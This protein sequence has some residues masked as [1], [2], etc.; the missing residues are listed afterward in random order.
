M[1][2]ARNDT[3]MYEGIPY[4]IT[5][6][7]QHYYQ[8]MSARSTTKGFK[9]RHLSQ[10]IMRADILFGAGAEVAGMTLPTDFTAVRVWDPVGDITFGHVMKRV[11][12][13]SDTKPGHR[14][15]MALLTS[16]RGV[17][18]LEIAVD[19]RHFARNFCRGFELLD[20]ATG[21]SYCANI[22]RIAVPSYVPRGPSSSRYT[23]ATDSATVRLTWRKPTKEAVLVYRDEAK[24]QELSRQ[25]AMARPN[26]FG[27]H[28]RALMFDTTAGE[29]AV[30]LWVLPLHLCSEDIT[31][32]LPQNLF[33]DRI[34]CTGPRGY[35]LEEEAGEMEALL[36]GLENIGPLASEP[37]REGV[38]DYLRAG[39]QTRF[40]DEAD[41][42]RAVRLYNNT[43]APFGRN[44]VV[45]VKLLFTTTFVFSAVCAGLYLLL[46]EKLRRIHPD[47]QFELREHAASG[48][49]VLKAVG[50]DPESMTEIRTALGE[51]LGVLSDILEAETPT[52]EARPQ[53][54]A[55]PTLGLLA[56]ECPR[57]LMCPICMDEPTTPIR[58]HCGHVYCRECY[59]SLAESAVGAGTNGTVNCVG[60]EGACEEAF[61]LAELRAALPRKSFKALLASSVKS[62]VRSHP[63]ELRFC[64][65]PDCQQLYRPTPAGA[66]VNAVARC[67]DCLVVL[68][69]ACHAPHDEGV[70]CG[71]GQG[72]DDNAAIREALG[73]KPCPQCRTPIERSGGCNHMQ[74]GAC[75][76]HICW[77]CMEHYRTSDE[78]YHH[79]TDIHGGAFAGIAGVDVYGGQLEEDEEEGH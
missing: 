53:E 37:C 51:T 45:N 6:P 11:K 33:P 4:T 42:R 12:A 52:A 78:C 10:G 35:G 21:T 26:P 61:P 70:S 28:V 44:V 75:R 50:E 48:T 68:C 19:D 27:P 72:E 58:S 39:Y 38:H 59:V 31:N 49:L 55:C 23:I 24:A 1:A 18:H 54:E 46:A 15:V 67:P 69:T 76:T 47:V 17:R 9:N 43:I 2:A 3:I 30:Q 66:N 16:R 22:E 5:S 73:I 40:V 20:E 34:I 62:Y 29:F 71:E 63:L 79:M 8:R 65:T 7:V 74:C 32:R 25:I 41:A 56:D 60:D 13:F 14:T 36:R 77:V 57:S 64:P